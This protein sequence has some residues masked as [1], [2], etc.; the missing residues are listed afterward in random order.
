MAI[1]REYE[2]GMELTEI[3]A[4]GE[5]YGGKTDVYEENN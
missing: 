3:K 4:R 5:E 1:F 2:S